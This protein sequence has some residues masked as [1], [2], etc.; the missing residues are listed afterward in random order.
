MIF[1]T[2]DLDYL[3][4]LADELEVGDDFEQHATKF[5]QLSDMLRKRIYRNCKDPEI[6]DMVDKLPTI[7][8]ES[9]QRS[10]FEQLLPKSGRDMVGDYKTK[11]KIRGQVRDALVRF[12]EIHRWLDE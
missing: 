4:Y 9:Y 1:P 10:F 2:E 5:K 6:L 8:L 7:K 11:E 12:Q 3:Q